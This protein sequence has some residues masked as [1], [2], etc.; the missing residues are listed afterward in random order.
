MKP[1]DLQSAKAGAP[2]V[3][4]DGREAKFVAHVPEANEGEKIVVLIGKS[5]LMYSENGNY[6]VDC[7]SNCDLFMKPQKRTVYVNIVKHYVTALQVGEEIHS[8]VYFNE[9]IAKK[10]TE[11]ADKVVAV[12]VPIEIEE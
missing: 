5:I 7:G 8:H 2:I 12:A 9:E 4:R 11:F 3:T 10:A 1:F 6:L